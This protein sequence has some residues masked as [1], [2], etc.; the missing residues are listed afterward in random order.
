MLVGII[1]GCVLG[2]ILLAIIGF[3][4]YRRHRRK[5]NANHG[6]RV[7]SAEVR[8]PG[9]IVI[10]GHDLGK[11][12]LVGDGQAT[13]NKRWGPVQTRSELTTQANRHEMEDTQVSGTL[14]G[15]WSPDVRA[16]LDGWHR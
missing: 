12:E 5:R 6:T 13:G 2:G 1:I 4:V 10:H 11:P 8:D 7:V 9:N 3:C 14:N 16:E 15:P